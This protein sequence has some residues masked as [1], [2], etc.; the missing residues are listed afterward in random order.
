[1]P[2]LPEKPSPKAA[3]R[4]AWSVLVVA[5]LFAMLSRTAV[6][7]SGAPAVVNFLHFPLVGLAYTLAR[8]RSR[9]RAIRT[10]E[11][12]LALS[13]ILTAASW[14]GGSD[15]SLLR[16]MLLWPVLMEPFVVILAVW[17]L[18]AQGIP[19]RWARYLAVGIVL[20][21][22]PIAV[23]QALAF[24]I[25]DAVQGTLVQ[26]GAG[27]HVLGAIGLM[28][29][30]AALATL[31]NGQASSRSIAIPAILGGFLL[32][33]ITDMKQGVA[34]FFLV[35]PFLVLRGLRQRR[36]T[37]RGF[38][39]AFP[40][41]LG[42]AALAA[43]LGFGAIFFN[44]GFRLA[45][46]EPWRLPTTLEAKTA[47]LSLSLA[48]MAENHIAYL[49]GLGPGTTFTRV[50]W[51]SS[52]LGEQSFL[53]ALRLKPT[54]IT[55]EMTNALVSNPLWMA[56]S[57][58]SPFSTWTGVFGDL[59]LLGLLTYAGLWWVSWRAARKSGQGLAAQ[60]V[61]LF[62]AALG[63]LFNWME[64][65]VLVM[66]AALV[67]GGTTSVQETPDDELPR[68]LVRRVRLA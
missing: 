56:S 46:T 37:V 7:L 39:S 8:R 53:Y 30:L 50:A 58:S 6:A 28:V 47:A 9:V 29:A 38:A 26:Q 63:F 48:A 13:A 4:L 24:G 14:L 45:V 61:I 42:A 59:G 16:T 18:S 43:A 35:L 51:L 65:P 40:R 19:S 36:I 64:E 5:V 15:S 3:A 68:R 49:V 60:A 52:P 31:M 12:L 23:G 1:M 62:T 33:V 44:Q 10:G 41:A 67:I 17:H 34:V 20:A 11:R 57:L 2:A 25:G 66:T 27:H 55:L 22:V 21:E 32:A 54:P